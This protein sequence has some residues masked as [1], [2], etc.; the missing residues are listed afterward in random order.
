MKQ[1]KLIGENKKNENQIKSDFP[2]HLSTLNNLIS[3]FDNTW[4]LSCFKNGIKI[5][6]NGQNGNNPYNPKKK[7]YSYL[8]VIIL[9]T[10]LIMKIF[11]LGLSFS[12][13][14]VTFLSI[15]AFSAIQKK[16]M[17]TKEFIVLTIY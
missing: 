7:I 5:Y 11:P 9:L 13:I 2:N 14:T 10:L 16:K 15:F 3:E 17:V 12:L 6:K 1:N 8:V 4:K